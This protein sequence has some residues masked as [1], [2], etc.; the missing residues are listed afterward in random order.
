MEPPS[1]I[2]YRDFNL[3]D[4]LYKIL[5]DINLESI[6]DC[7]SNIILPAYREVAWSQ[8]PLTAEDVIPPQQ[9]LEKYPSFG[10]PDVSTVVR[11]L[12]AVGLGSVL[13]LFV[14]DEVWKKDW[15]DAFKNN[16]YEVYK[17]LNEE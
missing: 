10:K 3:V 6:E 16:T 9:V 1:D 14:Y 11:H 15:T 2:R 7:L 17:W 12:R 13:T 8:M 5:N 4:H